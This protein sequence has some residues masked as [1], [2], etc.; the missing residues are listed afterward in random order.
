LEVKAK[1][2][3]WT[4]LVLILATSSLRRALRHVLGRIKDWSQVEAPPALW[5]KTRLQEKTPLEIIII[6]VSEL[7]RQ[8]ENGGMPSWNTKIIRI[9][10]PSQY[11][12]IMSLL[13]SYV[14]FSFR[15]NA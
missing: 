14:S 10:P 4:I 3:A 8:Q 1:S 5:Q 7:K 15:R 13:V 12:T 9:T 2:R 6:R 11:F